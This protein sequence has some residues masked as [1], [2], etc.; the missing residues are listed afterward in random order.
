MMGTKTCVACIGTGGTGCSSDTSGANGP[1]CCE[2]SEFSLV[3]ASLPHES[4]Y[5]CVNSISAYS[6]FHILLLIFSPVFS[7]P[8]FL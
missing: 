4:Y 3:F 2:T 7:C 5:S 8:L 1:I 6:L